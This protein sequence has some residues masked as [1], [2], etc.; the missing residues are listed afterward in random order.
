MEKCIIFTEHAKRRVSSTKW[1]RRQ[2]NETFR[3]IY[4][5]RKPLWL[6]RFQHQRILYKYT[7]WR[8]KYGWTFLINCNRGSLFRDL[9]QSNL[10]IPNSVTTVLWVCSFYYFIFILISLIYIWWMLHCNLVTLLL[11]WLIFSY[12]LFIVF[13]LYWLLAGTRPVNL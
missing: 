4:C 11:Q 1:E 9:I 13:P 6:L 5:N 8:R 2:R 7:F 12:L 3:L 10:E